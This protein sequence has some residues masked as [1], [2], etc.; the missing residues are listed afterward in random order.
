MVLALAKEEV[1]RRICGDGGQTE[2]A[3][4]EVAGGIASHI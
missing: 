4:A 2:Q 1:K 3:A